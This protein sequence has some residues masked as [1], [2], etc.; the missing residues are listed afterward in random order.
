VKMELA[1]ARDLRQ[2][3][4]CR[5]FFRAF[6]QAAGTGDSNG[7]LLR[8]ILGARA[9]ALAGTKTCGFGGFDAVMKVDILAPRQPRRAAGAA[10]DA[11]R[12]DGKEEGAVGAGVAL[13]DR[14]PTRV[15]AG[16]AFPVLSRMSFCRGHDLILIDW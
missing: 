14:C 1:H 8:Q 6:N 15:V 12:P 10:V 11:G 3:F 7:V 16:V 9:A 5:R 4:Q 2:A 13:G